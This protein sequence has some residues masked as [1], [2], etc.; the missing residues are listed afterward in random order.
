[1]LPELPRFCGQQFLWGKDRELALFAS[2]AYND[3]MV[4]EW[5]GRAGSVDPAVPGS[6][7]GRE[8][9]VA[10]VRRNA[11]RGVRAVAFS[12]LPT[13]LGLPSIYIGVLGPVL[14]GLRGA[15][16]VVCMHIGSGTRTPQTSPDGPDAVSGHASFSATAWRA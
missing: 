2:Q 9:A 15:G 6:A 8:L 13:Y 14:R 3:W 5:C 11:E 12:E 10:E 4:E 7:L 16:T 1:M